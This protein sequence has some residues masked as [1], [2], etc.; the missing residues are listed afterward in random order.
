MG[1]RPGNA[2]V[3]ASPSAPQSGHIDHDLRSVSDNRLASDR[4]AAVFEERRLATARAHR[5]HERHRPADIGF[6]PPLRAEGE[7]PTAL[8]SRRVNRRWLAGT[9]LTGFAG[10]LLMGGAIY[11]AMHGGPR[12]AEPPGLARPR[13]IGTLFGE[14]S[15]N[16]ARK[17]DRITVDRQVDESRQTFRVTTTTRVQDREVVRTRPITRIVAGFSPAAL[18]SFK[19]P[20]FNPLSI[21]AETSQD[22][23]DAGPAPDGD[24]SY[25]LLDLDDPAVGSDPGPVVSLADVVA[26]VRETLAF[27]GPHPS[28]AGADART[29]SPV[30]AG[31]GAGPGRTDGA[32]PVRPPLPNT[33]VLA[34][35]RASVADAPSPGA[36]ATATAL[37]GSEDER[38]VAVTAP[39]RLET[40]LRRSGVAA[41]DIR[42]IA[43]TLGPQSGYGTQA[44]M[45]GQKVKL[46]FAPTGMAD[47]RLQMVRLSIMNGEETETT[48]A[49]SDTGGWVAVAGTLDVAQEADDDDDDDDA[50][51]GK[52]GRPGR[53]YESLYATAVQKGVP[54]PVIEELV[55]VFGNDADFQR[56]V[57]GS[58]GFE[59][60]YASDDDGNVEGRPEVLYS[61]LTLGG[62]V[63]RYYRFQSPADGAVDYF[64]E[65]G[66][67]ADKFLVRKPM[68]G[69][70]FTRGFGMARHPILGYSRMHTGVDWGAPRG[71]PV[72]ASGSGVVERADWDGGYGRLIR[73]KH[74]N[75]YE[76]SYG[77]LSAFARNIA[78][79]TRVRQGQIVGY[80]GSTGLS[81]GPHLHFEIIVNGRFVD[82]M[83]IRI[84]RA[85]ELDGEELARFNRQR[86]RIEALRTRGPSAAALLPPRGTEAAADGG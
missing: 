32:V 48:V 19:P 45:P 8:S 37:S 18:A 77:H 41:A 42:A 70:H 79:G 23:A 82:P 84:P 5:F 12:V 1:V 61:S 80:V 25:K 16:A 15:S 76:T 33:T 22:L 69:G 39:E 36:A 71:S 68:A 53:L 31:L 59:V 35:T 78:P 34:K 47:G 4:P 9:V 51:A 66:R 81:T 2:S 28:A 74:A 56:R 17:G 62:E 44:L 3:G 10:C 65:N 46:L 24:V 20:P 11:T 83:R 27:E 55:H 86:Q 54:K 64:D 30:L 63:K 60:M 6:E 57:T 72:Y 73:I 40:L 26:K 52:G 85:R 21:F 7:E 67:S 13:L 29:L 50:D 14:R 38:I 49:Q 58:D 75:G 43:D